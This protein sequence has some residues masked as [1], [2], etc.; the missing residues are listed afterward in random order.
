MVFELQIL[1]LDVSR[2]KLLRCHFW[3][4]ERWWYHRVHI[5]IRNSGSLRPTAGTGR[6]LGMGI[7]LTASLSISDY[8][9][10][11]LDQPQKPETRLRLAILLF[12]HLRLHWGKDLKCN[13]SLRAREFRIWQNLTTGTRDSGQKNKHQAECLFIFLVVMKPQFRYCNLTQARLWWFMR[14]KSH[15]ADYLCTLF[16]RTRVCKNH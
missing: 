11:L 7:L 15:W 6:V 5:L 12:S 1:S 10:S 16:N 4:D 2:Q 13:C 14:N 3:Y 9:L 8:A